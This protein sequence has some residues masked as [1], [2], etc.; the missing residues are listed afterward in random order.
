MA[1][2]CRFTLN[3]KFWVYPKSI[4]SKIK[5]KTPCT[6]DSEQEE[7]QFWRSTVNN[8][9][10]NVKNMNRYM[11]SQLVGYTLYEAMQVYA[12]SLVLI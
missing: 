7:S 12:R 6:S 2:Y 3:P 1:M 10:I 11:Y 8:Q 5:S 4:K 9:I